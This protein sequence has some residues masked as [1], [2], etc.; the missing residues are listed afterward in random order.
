MGITARF[1]RVLRVAKVDVL[2]PARILPCLLHFDAIQLLLYLDCLGLH[3]AL[4]CSI[5]VRVG[6][7]VMHLSAASVK[8]DGTFCR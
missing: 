1:I 5:V 2:G 4:T 3:E 8:L 7:Q 6:V